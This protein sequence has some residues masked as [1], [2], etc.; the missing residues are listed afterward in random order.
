MCNGLL[1]AKSE[2][3]AL[4]IL[5]SQRRPSSGFSLMI[6]QQGRLPIPTSI[7]LLNIQSLINK[8]D[9]FLNEHKLRDNN[10]EI[11]VENLHIEY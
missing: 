9:D 2:M 6:L 8:I 11:Y 10:K 5:V 4:F 7:K 1:M 3:T